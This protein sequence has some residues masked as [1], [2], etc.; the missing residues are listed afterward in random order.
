MINQVVVVAGGKGSR[1][2]SYLGSTPK[3]LMKL[4]ESTLLEMYVKKACEFKIQS[5]LFLLHNGAE[6]VISEIKKIKKKYDIRINFLV[7][8]EPLGTGG[9]L[10]Y[11][12]K[13]LENEFI[14]FYG[15]IYININLSNYLSFFEI[16]S[17]RYAVF[18]HPNSHMY[19]SDIIE[20]GSNNEIV[21]FHRKPHDHKL[22]IRNNVNSG[23]YLIRKEVLSFAKDLPTKFDLD[24][25]LIPKLISSSV[26]GR[27]IRNLGIIKDLGTPERFL[28]FKNNRNIQAISYKRPAIFLDRDGTINELNGFINHE[29]QLKLYPEVPLS[30]RKFNELGFWVIVVTNQPVVARGEATPAK[31][32]AIHAE[33]DSQLSDHGAYVDDYFVCFHHPDKGFPGE[34]KEFKIICECRKPKIGLINQATEKY[35]IDLNQS[36]IV[37]DTWRDE[38]LAINSNIQFCQIN[39]GDKSNLGKGI[40]NS[41]D[42][43]VDL[44]PTNR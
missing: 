14:L 39:R 44:L 6:E 24:K 13:F 40:I 27:T 15:D 28:E 8:P 25:E 31:I 23:L 16:D 17:A 29:T 21:K 42:Q 11:A 3:I 34:N 37:G 38:L 30:I 12:E 41:L 22:R 5:I 35:P 10:K 43:L 20:I 18:S 33:I 1:L 32:N 7:E 36:I 19:D 4:N 9:S 26:L 2:K